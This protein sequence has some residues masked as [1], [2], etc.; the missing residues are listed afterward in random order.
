MVD[1]INKRLSKTEVGNTDIEYLRTAA[2]IYYADVS[3]IGGYHSFY[4]KVRK[5]DKQVLILGQIETTKTNNNSNNSIRY[6][7]TKTSLTIHFALESS[8]YKK[9]GLR[10]SQDLCSLVG[11]LLRSHNLKKS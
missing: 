10:H 9:L 2:K 11:P 5:T 8:K 7:L 3:N 1:K 6:K 4:L